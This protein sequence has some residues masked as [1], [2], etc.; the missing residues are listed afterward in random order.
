M[1]HIQSKYTLT[2]IAFCICISTSLLSVIAQEA[3]FK[4]PSEPLK[5]GAFQAQFDPG[6][7]FKL[8]GAG[9]PP[10]SGNWKITGNEIELTTSGGPGGCDK[11]GRY[12]VRKE[13]SKVGF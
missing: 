8:Q 1:N 3:T 12:K 4:L 5:F 13:G 7:T 9:W 6:G 2:Y 10:L 11:P